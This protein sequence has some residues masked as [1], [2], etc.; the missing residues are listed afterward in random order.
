M[1][2][3][4]A[5]EGTRGDIYPMLAL[6]AA[7]RNKGHDVIVCAPP[8]FREPTEARKLAFHPVGRNVRAY[9]ECEAVALHGGAIAMTSAG[10]RFFKENLHAQM[11]DLSTGADGADIILAAGT[12]LAASSIAEYVGA[13][14]RFVAYDPGVI[15]S[16]ERPPAMLPFANTPPR[17]VKLSWA[18]LLFFMDRRIR[19]KLDRERS[20]CGL[21]R[22]RH[23]LYHQLL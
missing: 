2:V 5:A 8:D 3:A 17:L 15:R 10:E 16:A 19:P 12:Q 22:V 21:P 23:D 11:R 4:I 9:L 14:Y 20:Y 1:R 18:L 13:D 6:G 7:L